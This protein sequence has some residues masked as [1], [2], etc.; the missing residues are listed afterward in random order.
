MSSLG[1]VGRKIKRPDLP[2][3]LQRKLHNPRLISLSV[4]LPELRIPKRRIR[5]R[6]PRRIRQIKELRSELQVHHIAKPEVLAQRGIDLCCPVASQPVISPWRIPKGI[7]RRNRK[8][9]R[10]NP[11]LR[12]RLRHSRI[13]PRPIRPLSSALRERIIRH[14]CDPQRPSAEPAPNRG[15]LP[16]AQQPILLQKWGSS[17]ESV[18]KLRFGQ[19]AK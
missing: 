8:L 2:A 11:P 10:V 14:R 9:R 15:D 4:H 5:R 19:L 13:H 6:E 7:C 12:S 18:G 3:Q 16:P 1:R 17:E